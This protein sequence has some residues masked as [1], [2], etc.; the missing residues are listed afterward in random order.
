MEIFTLHNQDQLQLLKNNLFLNNKNMNENIEQ[1]REIDSMINNL[2]VE[3]RKLNLGP[4]GEYEKENL[5]L[6]GLKIDEIFTMLREK[7]MLI[8]DRSI[9]DTLYSLGIS[10]RDIDL[11]KDVWGRWISLK[12]ETGEGRPDTTAE[13]LGFGK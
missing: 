3:M 8:K 10:K 11:L 1:H 13:P 2:L 9:G 12:G 5:E 6:V 7:K 4:A